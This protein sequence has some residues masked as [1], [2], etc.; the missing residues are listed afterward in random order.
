MELKVQ[1]SIIET[2]SPPVAQLET[3]GQFRAVTFSPYQI[4]DRKRND[5]VGWRRAAFA[6]GQSLFKRTLPIV[7]IVKGGEIQG[8]SFMRLDT[9]AQ[10]EGDQF[11]GI[12]RIGPKLR[13]ENSRRKHLAI[14]ADIAFSA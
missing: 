9:V 5:R 1:V 13:N 4:I 7:N 2:D 14:N 11:F 8:H 12:D 6:K 3:A 10:L